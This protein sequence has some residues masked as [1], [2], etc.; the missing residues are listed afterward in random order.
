MT[1]ASSGSPRSTHGN[2]L[3]IQ[4]FGFI[5][6]PED[7]GPG[8]QGSRARIR[9]ALTAIRLG[10]ID[11]TRLVAVFPQKICTT[12]PVAPGHPS[13]LGAMMARELDA[14]L[15]RELPGQRRIMIDHRPLS[16]NTMNDV[17]ATYQ[18]VYDLGY[19]SAHISFVSDWW[20]LWRIRLVWW[21]THTQL[22]NYASWS[23]DFIP[24]PEHARP[25]REC[26]PHEIGGCFK[27]WWRLRNYTRPTFQYERRS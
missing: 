7:T 25:L 17:L 27:Y 4:S 11:T 21:L 13:C 2:I 26:L 14:I 6:G 24:A 8:A 18:M 22:P 1:T 23:A 16:N 20:H 15:T 3:A 9:A 19:E 10:R 12:Q 5:H